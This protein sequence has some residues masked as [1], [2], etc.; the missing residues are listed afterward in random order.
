MTSNNTEFQKKAG[1]YALLLYWLTQPLMGEAFRL[2]YW[3]NVV[4]LV[5]FVV[6]SVFIFFFYQQKQ[7]TTVTLRGGEGAV[8]LGW[9]FYMIARWMLSP[10]GGPSGGIG[11]IALQELRNFLWPIPVF[12]FMA[13]R[14]MTTR[15]INGMLLGLVL[16]TPFSIVLQAQAYD[17]FSITELEDFVG[18]QSG[19]SY[20]TFVPYL[21]FSFFAGIYL[22]QTLRSWVI[23]S[24]TVL[25]SVMI[26]VFI[27]I[28]PSRQSVMFLFTGLIIMLMQTKWSRLIWLAPLIGILGLMSWYALD[29]FGKLEHA[30]MRFASEETFETSRLYYAQLGIQSM[31][32]TWEWLFGR[33]LHLCLDAGLV[34]INPHNSYIFQIMRVG[35]IGTVLLYFPFVYALI[36]LIALRLQCKR[37]YWFDDKLTTFATIGVTFTLFHSFFGQPLQCSF[38]S[39]VCWFALAIWVSLR[40]NTIESSFDYRK[41]GCLS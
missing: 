27:L 16:C 6:F 41:K 31:E 14:G 7:N 3:G 28:N 22:A 17:V 20:N 4:S 18:K 21:T 11:S 2:F 1:Y 24:F 5:W 37:Q 30:Q 36:G 10:S 8:V 12:L 40:Q 19:F 38:N 39:S 9:A 34:Q 15:E 25:C 35:L 32:G 13:L 29:E 26:L 33:G 23:K